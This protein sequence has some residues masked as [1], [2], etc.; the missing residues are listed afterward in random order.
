MTEPELTDLL[1][2][3]EAHIKRLNKELIEYQLKEQY[4]SN[5]R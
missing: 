2:D 1:A 5:G 3:R 4:Q